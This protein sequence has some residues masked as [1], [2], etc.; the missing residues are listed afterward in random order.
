MPACMTPPPMVCLL[1]CRNSE[2]RPIIFPNQSI[3]IV[4]SSVAAGLDA[5]K[6]TRNEE[7]SRN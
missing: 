4:S 1:L 3:T 5:C 7:L 2:G 6:Y